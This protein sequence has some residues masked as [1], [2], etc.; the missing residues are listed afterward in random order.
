MIEIPD[1]LGII[2]DS[3]KEFLQKDISPEKRENK[4]LEEA[5]RKV[6][7]IESEDGLLKLEYISYNIEEPTNTVE[8]CVE[9]GI[10]YEGKL[11]VKFR[12]L[13]NGKDEKGNLKNLAIKEQEVYVGGIP[14]MTESGSFIING[15][16]RT[17]VNQL[18]R[19]PGVY[20]KEEEEI[21][22]KTLYS[23]KIYPARGLWI[24]FYIDQHE[25]INILIG[26][27]KI[28]GSTFLRAL[29]IEE[30]ELI[31]E[32]YGDE[33]DV[34]E[35]SIIKLTFLKDVTKDR[36]DAL[37]YI[38]SEL[39]PGYPLILKEAERFL[40]SLFFTNETYDLSE[41]GRS[42]INKKLGLNLKE[43]HLTN[44]D[45]KGV[46]KYLVKLYEKKEGE[47]DDIDHLGN[48][49][50]RTSAE[51]IKEHVYEGL[52][53]LARYCKEKMA[54]I[55]KSKIEDI[56]PQDLINHRFFTNV[57]NDFFARNQ[58]SQ[59]LDKT[60][61][62][63][64]ITHK[65]RVTAVGEGGIKERK[66]AGFEVR[67]VHYTHFGKI[68]PIETPE[69]A[70]IGLINSLTVYA[71]V[72]K[73]GFL[74]AP[75]YKVENGIVRKDKIEFL[76]AD[77]EE[78]YNIASPDV[79]YDE[80]T[81]KIKKEKVLVRG[82]EGNFIE[83]EREKIDYIGISPVQMVS[84]S[85]S[86]IPFLEHDDSNRALMGSNM[87]RQAV[88]LIKPESPIVKTGIEKYVVRDTGAVIKAKNSGIVEYVDAEK[89]IVKKDKPGLFPWEEKD[90]YYLKKFNRTNQDTCF[91]Q[92]PI[93]DVGDKV[94]EGQILTDGYAISKDGEL[95]LG[96]NLLVAFM[97]WHG[98]NYEDAILISERVVKE[99]IFTSIHIKEF[100]V[101][102]RDTELGPE[103]ITAD[104]PNVPEEQLAH[105]DENGIVKIGTEVEPD[106]IIVGKITPR[107]ESELT[108]E[109]KLL[110]VIF[111]EKS[112]N[113]LNTSERVPPGV[114]GVVINV[115]KYERRDLEND[116]KAK[117]KVEKEVA[118][119]KSNYKKKE[120]IV[121]DI[122]TN[123]IKNY[124]EKKNL[125]IKFTSGISGWEKLLNK[126]PDEAR[127]DLK[128]IIDIGKSEIEKIEIECREEEAKIRKGYELPPDVRIK[129]VVEIAMKKKIAVGDKMS[130]R[131]GNKGVIAKILP[132]EDMPFLE[133][134]TPVDIVLN[135]LGVPS[136]MN[137]GQILET[138]LGWA[139]KTL[140]YKLE[141][142]VFQGIKEFEIK[143]LL[144][145]AGLPESGKTI[146]YDGQ[147]GE[148]FY[149]PVTVGYMYMMKLI[150]LADEKIHA[151]CTG[152]YSLI[153]QQPLGGRAQ[154]GG[155][156]FGEM[157]VWALE[158]YGAAYTLREMLT[159]KSDDTEGR[160]Q[161]YEAIAKGIDYKGENIPESFK[162]LKRELQGLGFDMRLE[163]RRIGDREKEVV[164]IR[165][166]TPTVIRS[167]S[168]GE[169]KKAETLNYRTL[170]P[171]RDGLFCE[172]I[173]G[174]E[175]DYEC[176]CGKYKKLRYKGIIC[177][178]CGVEVTTR[179]VR[180][181]RMGHIELATPVSYVWLFKSVA[182]WLGLLLDLSQSELEMVIYYERYI[183]IDPG[184]LPELKEKMLLKEEEYHKYLEK[185]GN[186]F[187]V[188]IGAEGIQ[189]L[190]KK[191][192]LVKLEEGLKE[193]IKKKQKRTEEKKDL[194]KKLR[195][196]QGLLKTQV[197]PEYLV[198][199]IIPVIPPDL[200]P[201]LPLDG[202]RFVA[203]DLNDLYQRVINRNN[204]L[205]KLIKLQTPDI[206]IRN[207]K[208]LLQEAVDA[209]MDNGRHGMPV[210]GKGKRP[211][212]SLA[213]ALRG[214]QG[215]FRQN[216]LGKRVDYSGRAVI[217]VGPNLK[218]NECGI[219]KEMALE[220]F[221]PFVLREFRK[222]EYFHTLGSAK[223]A[224][225][226]NRPE[227]WEILEKVIRH[228][229]VL[230]NRQPTLHRLSIQAFEPR[231]I[232]GHVIA[233]HPLVCP[234]YNADFDGDTMS[235]HVPLTPEAIL[236][237]EL[238]MKATTHI[239][240]PANGRPVV[241]PTRDIVMG[242]AYLTY[243]SEEKEYPKVLSSFDEA[244]YL[245]YIGEIELHQPINVKDENGNIIKT[246]VGRIIFNE[247]LPSKISFKNTNFESSSLEKLIEEIF[248]KCGY[249]KTVEFLDACKELGFYYA[250]VSGITIGID[251][252]VVPKEK[253]ELIKEA[254]DEVEKVEKNYKKGIISE[255]ERYNRKIDIWTSVSNELMELVMDTIKNDVSLKPFRINPIYLMVSSGARGNKSQVTQ[256]M[257][258]R[259][260]MIRPTKKLTGGIGEIIE[261]PVISNFR[262]G[263]SVF[264]YFISVHGGRKGLV[265]T[266]LKTSEAGYL[267][268]RL[269][270]VAHSVIVTQYDCG[271]L[272]GVYASPLIEREEE[273]IPLKERIIGRVALDDVVNI[274]GDVI[275]KS[276]E[277]ID[278]EKA[279]MIIRAREE[280]LLLTNK[281]KIR[282][283]LTCR[284]E[285]GV[286]AK[287]YGWD[288]SRKKLVNIGEAVGIVAA[289]SIGEP[290]TQLTLRTFHT[291]GAASRGV[292]PSTIRSKSDGIV[293][294][295]EDLK[296]VKNKEGKN[297]VCQR[298]G[299]IIIVD[300]RDR[301]L[302][303][304]TLR[305]GS[306]I[307]YG[308]GERVKRGDVIAEWDPYSIPVVVDKG[309]IVKYKDIEV[310]KT[311]KEEVD[312]STKRRNLII[313]PHKEE[314]D[315]QIVLY[316]END[317]IVGSY[318]I[319]IGAHIIVNEGDKV[320]PGDIIA[321][322]PR[323]VGRIQDITGGLP[324][325]S[326]LF[327]ARASKNPAILSEIEGIVHIEIEK[328]MRK[329]IVKNE[330][331]NEIREYVIPYGKTIVVGEGDK[332]L[333]GTELTDGFKS[334]NDILRIQ[335][336]KKVM[337]YLL[338][339]IQ[340][341][342][343]VEGV[344]INDKHIEVIIRQMLSRVRIED[345]G[346][347]YLL[348]GEEINRYEIQK[349]NESLPKGKRPATFKP[350]VLGITKVALTCE[351]F[352]SAA[353]FQETMRVLTDAAVLGAEDYLEGLK[354]NVILGRLIPAGTGLFEKKE[355]KEEEYQYILDKSHMGALPEPGKSER[356][357]IN[358]KMEVKDANNK[359]TFEKGKKTKS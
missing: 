150:H 332:V 105:L 42:Q 213:D 242:C 27:K 144:K 78:K 32:I 302:E 257:G 278:E 323:T 267:S 209:L 11:R 167:W 232:E 286:C 48:K 40:N 120:K 348:E 192:D 292:G 328:G 58:L 205:K 8:E 70:N 260:L 146:L 303:R 69:G 269:V 44:G 124:L 149:Q 128:K 104:I 243:M 354:E 135:P 87:Q 90:V 191:I 327:E 147:T 261:T 60:N 236:E 204:R 253:M 312:T 163:K 106:D 51:I 245:N 151:R 101:E 160:K 270:D 258:M 170:K 102:A 92:R 61:P 107:G 197:K 304:Y 256:L 62:L 82:K 301:E 180:R 336:E 229:P 296:V 175:K 333:A 182:N 246:T 63:A 46:I 200:R 33:K 225:R 275:V 109:E 306:I 98:Y 338:N 203:S 357:S 340:K 138:H 281:I 31:K 355:E 186:K 68:C 173:F 103:E 97:P 351:S 126:V 285:K 9:E 77:E 49:R 318:H 339:E 140:G 238:L 93:V 266:A 165:I 75:Y 358:M 118:Q 247:I 131:H 341:V 15:I 179:K 142:P 71:K 159:V 346:D 319:P 196:V 161:M 210:L 264:E 145:E 248:T 7:P 96:R 221:S 297:V 241:T 188:G 176:A 190:L 38:Y 112:K 117:E 34:P 249:E 76:S 208:R 294:Y 217:V 153:T 287:C 299:S 166:A 23:A 276:G 212:K 134:G 240:S 2:K 187:K 74:R 37:K 57:L 86:L 308:N 19:C 108:P 12:L 65:R 55:G 64:E 110:R 152:S 277:V 13:I 347:T 43:R 273:I 99:D 223:K 207:E 100:A 29:G 6:F 181:E 143:Q 121:R 222:K 239:L 228:H 259:G 198:T 334:L 356:I 314:M 59:F 24:E 50:V 154:F 290:G 164:T 81:G 83:I 185:Y 279:E 130:G 123:E 283:V 148:P 329:V 342:Y 22:T 67:D 206:I 337:E 41:A 136:R 309:G 54:I 129:V 320:Y 139:L 280:G 244:K 307:E 1:L 224:I 311:V 202:G 199:N 53:R 305:V 231:L 141:V 116:E 47:V 288:L 343:R 79:P 220:L 111:G 162:V 169:V 189:E 326:D 201:L 349:I 350:L 18:L 352:I 91:H 85:A 20:F 268:R 157:E 184:N 310:G 14:L 36:E 331:T 73:L 215:R 183:V 230:L 233:I 122:I 125:K 313:I 28:L 330:E 252:L 315:P 95:A 89:I 119:L 345:P 171:E 214:K 226:E 325:V 177:D 274:L 322:N 218:L 211:L 80:E 284:A 316:D 227:V 193:E 155:Q 21:I 195:M 52:V 262:E 94:E 251:D 45:I 174:P 168:Y 26:K 156:R 132:E 317:K 17:V 265:D 298:E 324:R 127:D 321:K 235:I 335:G 289:Q 72:D 178:R 16:E 344:K 3:Y 25:V 158:G 4:G 300:D 359:S 219:P 56:S 35:N 10:N 115:R 255:G 254:K 263:L 295:L 84:V 353:S 271:T 39:R 66:R 137:V 237:A 291:G 114:K 194:I 133:D 250:T 88:P 282:S 272:E 5:F 293:K 216:L 113:V 172:K 30:N 234:A